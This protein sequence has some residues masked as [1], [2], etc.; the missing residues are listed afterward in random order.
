[1]RF[2]EL[3]LAVSQFRQTR[4]VT[5][6]RSPHPLDTSLKLDNLGIGRRHGARDGAT[7]G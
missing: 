5:A 7:A 6:L 4:K 2:S 1:M 3:P